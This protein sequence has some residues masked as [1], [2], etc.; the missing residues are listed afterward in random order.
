[1]GSTRAL[2]S[3]SELLTPFLLSSSISLGVRSICSVREIRL[4]TSL[5][6]H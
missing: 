1:M 4:R 5:A 6:C 2:P 3:V